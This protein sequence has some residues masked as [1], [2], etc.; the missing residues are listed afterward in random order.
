MEFVAFV[1]ENINPKEELLLFLEEDIL[2]HLKGLQTLQ[3]KGYSIGIIN[4]HLLSH[5]NH[6]FEKTPF[7]YLYTFT[8]PLETPHLLCFSAGSSKLPKAVLRT[9]TSWISS[10]S[11]QQQL[12]EYPMNTKS[13][14][15]GKLSH[16][17]HFFGLL[18][19]FHRNQ[20]PEVLPVFSPKRFFELCRKNPPDLL[21]ATPAQL[22]LIVKYYEQNACPP[23]SALKFILLGG[24]RVQPALISAFQKI[25][26]SAAIRVFFGATETSYISFKKADDPVDSVGKLCPGV[27]VQILDKK[28]QFVPNGTTGFIWVKSNQL[29]SKIILGSDTIDRNQEGYVCIGDRGYLDDSN[30]LYFKGRKDQVVTVAGQKISLDALEET[31][32]SLLKTEEIAVINIPNLVKENELYILVSKVINQEIKKNIRFELQTRF[33]SFVVPK[34]IISVS[35]WPL[36]ASGKTNRTQLK[37][38]ALG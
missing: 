33:G 23:V 16:S 26:P 30:R 1:G 20:L 27:A 21:Y 38:I 3:G 17:L 31:L 37:K 5:F 36:L 29:L 24:A 28:H 25:A 9:H 10:F 34:K 11:I 19:S 35:K 14:I 22:W 8:I 15:I 6:R 13:L 2:Q 18:E 4:K 7:S 12:L 32:K